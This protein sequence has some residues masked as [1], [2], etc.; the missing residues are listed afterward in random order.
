MDTMS[1]R[2]NS[3]SR[4]L[5]TTETPGRCVD[6]QPPAAEP[7]CPHAHPTP[8]SD[9]SHQNA[10]YYCCIESPLSWLFDRGKRYKRL[11][12]K[13][14]TKEIQKKIPVRHVEE[15]D[16]C[17]EL[18]VLYD[19]RSPSSSLR[20][21][22]CRRFESGTCRSVYRLLSCRNINM[23]S[24]AWRFPPMENISSAWGTNTT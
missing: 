18:V 2:K 9:V 12:N 1:N 17:R 5:K 22:T 14:E 16:A 4:A 3:D 11:R 8:V 20:A 19:R 24:P 21:A 15:E 7:S 23:E 6:H 13:L 10:F